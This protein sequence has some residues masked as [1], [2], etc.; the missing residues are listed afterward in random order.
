MPQL[1]GNEP[2]LGLNICGQFSTI[3]IQGTCGARSFS[4]KT[5]HSREFEGWC[6][7]ML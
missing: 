6:V 7:E 4:K 1:M 5:G 2:I 3:D